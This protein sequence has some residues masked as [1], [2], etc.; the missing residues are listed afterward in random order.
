VT[1]L[2]ALRELKKG[3]ARYAENRPTHPRRGA[4]QRRELSTAQRPFAAILTC[5]DSRVVPEILFDQGLGDLFVVRNGGNVVDDTVLGT[6]E[7]GAAHLKTPLIVVLGHTRCGAVTAAV[8][9]DFPNDHTRTLMR[10]LH[11]AVEKS[12][13]RRGDPVEN[14]SRRNVGLSVEN[15]RRSKPTLAPLCKSGALRIVGALYDIE[16][17][18]VDWLAA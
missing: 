14:A 2:E 15:L 11:P 17:G 7:Y 10:A 6:L 1:A 5:S 3:N 13:V 8:R 9:G 16:T 18:L 4:K 12:Y